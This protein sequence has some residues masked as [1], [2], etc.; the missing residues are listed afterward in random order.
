MK[1]LSK[2]SL[3]DFLRPLRVDIGILSE[4]A[5]RFEGTYRRLAAESEEQF[6][7]TPVRESLLRPGG[8]ERGRYE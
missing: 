2:E 3:D 5:R 1:L 6:L 8:I 7:G 4:L